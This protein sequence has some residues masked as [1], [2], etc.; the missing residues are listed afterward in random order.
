MQSIVFS[1]YFYPAWLCMSRK[2]KVCS[3]NRQNKIIML[4][5]LN[6]EGK[7]YLGPVPCPWIMSRPSCCSGD[8]T[9]LLLVTSDDWD[10]LPRCRVCVHCPVTGERAAAKYNFNYFRLARLLTNY[11]RIGE[12]R[13]FT[14]H[15]R[16]EYSHVKCIYRHW[17]GIARLK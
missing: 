8:V 6:C 12:D 2:C 11:T 13:T 10:V 17:L 5:I 7:H 9:N 14:H 15:C 16:W 1:K 3:Q 4:H